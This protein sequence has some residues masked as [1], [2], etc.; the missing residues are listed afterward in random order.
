MA[1]FRAFPVGV[2]DT[3]SDS[4]PFLESDKLSDSL[5]GRAESIA[6]TRDVTFKVKY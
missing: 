1:S 6:R 2:S 3:Q 5:P 4:C